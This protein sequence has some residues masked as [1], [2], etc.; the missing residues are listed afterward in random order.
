MGGVMGEYSARWVALCFAAIAW[1]LPIFRTAPIEL[2][3]GSLDGQASRKGGNQP[4]LPVVNFQCLSMRFSPIL[5][6]PGLYIQSSVVLEAADR[7]S[8]LRQGQSAIR[9]DMGVKMHEES[10]CCRGEFGNRQGTCRHSLSERLC[11]WPCRQEAS[12]PGRTEFEL[13]RGEE[14]HR[15]QC[16]RVC[17]H[18]K[19]GLSSLRRGWRWTSGWHIV[20]CGNTRESRGS[21]LQCLKSIYVK[22]PGGPQE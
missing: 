16:R 13:G 12:P 3:T 9:Y 10:H 8:S 4:V 18:G 22:L 2:E 17:C 15:C 14:N 7:I 6:L 5:D 20:H 21:S 1:T 19:C 11:D